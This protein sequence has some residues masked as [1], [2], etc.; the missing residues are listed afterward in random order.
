MK[1]HGSTRDTATPAL[2][3]SALFL[4]AILWLAAPGLAA[5]AF[6]CSCFSSAT[7][8]NSISG[9]KPIFVALVLR[10]SDSE[11]L[12]RTTRLRI[13]ERLVNAS[14]LPNEIEIDTMA[15]TSC[16]RRLK[17]GERYVVF[18]DPAA[19]AIAD[20]R[21]GGCNPT[22]ALRGKEHLLD[23]LRNGI[24]RGPARLTGTV[25]RMETSGLNQRIVPGAVVTAVSPEGE[26]SAASDGEGAF[27]IP[28]IQ[29]GRY[30][31]N[32]AKPG[33]LPADDYNHRRSGRFV[34]NK[35]TG[36]VQTDPGDATG[37]VLITERSCTDWSLALWPDLAISGRVVNKQGLPVEGVTVQAFPI[38]TAGGR[39]SSPLRTAK[40]STTGEFTLR[41]LPDGEYSIGVNAAQF[42]DTEPY[43]ATSFPDPVHV[44]EGR[45]VPPINLILPA[46][47]T[48]ATL[49]IQVLGPDGAPAGGSAVTLTD[50]SG[51]TQDVA[52]RKTSTTGTLTLPVYLGEQYTVEARQWPSGPA[53]LAEL[54]GQE[55]VAIT[56]PSAA[57]VVVIRPRQRP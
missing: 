26:Y 52:E 33:Y 25:H 9:T 31:L 7:P 23:A 35:E 50:S 32:V 24:A 53:D 22:F 46:E 44:A 27:T 41:P 21:V 19:T 40:S 20:W 37:S 17:T 8:C 49:R 38:K 3:P 1:M 30:R 43:P 6:A 51:R 15:G 29:P 10:R 45:P 48:T 16:Q 34:L 39:E 28:G 55:Q 42:R 54:T 18:P 5:P 12:A 4:L 47:R 2:V 36:K 57:I 11:P 13:E 14:G 56:A